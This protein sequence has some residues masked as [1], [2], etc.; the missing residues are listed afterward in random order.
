MIGDR[1][2][3]TNQREINSRATLRQQSKINFLENKTIFYY[4]INLKFLHA[5]RGRR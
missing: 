1:Q 3:S 2:K 5:Y 4:L